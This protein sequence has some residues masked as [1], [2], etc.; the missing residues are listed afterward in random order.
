[1]ENILSTKSLTYRY[2]QR[3][4]DG[5][6]DLNIELKR[7]EI[8][9][10]L[11]PS[12]AGKT[13]ILK[14]LAGKLQP[15]AGEILFSDNPVIGYVQ[16]RLNNLDEINVFEFISEGLDYLEAEQRENQ[17]RSIL[18]QLDLT[19][20]IESLLSELSGG[21]LQR[22]TLAKE[23]AKNP[24][25]LFFDEPFANLDWSL[26]E[27]LLDE[28]MPIIKDREITVIWTTHH[29]QEVFPFADRILLINSGEVQDLGSPS[30]L[31]FKPNNIFTALY[32]GKNNLLPGSLFGKSSELISLRPNQIE[33]KTDEDSNSHIAI[34]KE[35]QSFGAY[36]LLLVLWQEHE[37]WI[38]VNPNKTVPE[39][40][41]INWP[42]DSLHP[43]S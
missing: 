35:I 28:V 31:Y 40:V 5:V 20:E 16:Q 14:L 32:F 18:S 2:D 12:G 3:K 39:K 23:L 13:T 36:D 4:P 33:I 19:N 26:K 25:I 7:G 34:V 22:V 41:Y 9:A 43:L 8:L 38:Q 21:Q 1:M 10:L 27:D 24:S 17:V 30:D 37:V 6:L 15:Q 42:D 29:Y 11:G